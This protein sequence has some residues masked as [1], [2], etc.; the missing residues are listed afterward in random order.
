MGEKFDIVAGRA[1]LGFPVVSDEEGET[2]D[3]VAACLKSTFT[4][5]VAEG[6]TEST[7]SA[8]GETVLVHPRDPKGPPRICVPCLTDLIRD[9][10]Q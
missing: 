3:F 8:C 7:C 10:K 5:T 4:G 9:G 6:S 1:D 2:C